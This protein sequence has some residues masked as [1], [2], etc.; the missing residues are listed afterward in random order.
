MSACK[1]GSTIISLWLQ[2]TVQL[3]SRWE[4]GLNYH[5]SLQDVGDMVVCA[6]M[7]VSH[8]QPR[9]MPATLHHW[10]MLKI[11]PLNNTDV[12]MFHTR[13]QKSINRQLSVKL[14]HGL[15]GLAIKV[16]HHNVQYS[17]TSRGSSMHLSSHQ[18]CVTFGERIKLHIV[19]AN[20]SESF[21]GLL[22]EVSHISRGRISWLPLILLQPQTVHSVH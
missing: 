16:G 22:W 19:V 10:N 20:Q 4:Q 13:T 21:C 8:L 5:S 15:H 12:I 11:T 6:H 2:G 3:C 14:I 9:L 17:T 18:S 1:Q 7:T